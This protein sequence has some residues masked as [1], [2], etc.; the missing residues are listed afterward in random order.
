MFLAYRDLRVFKGKY[1]IIVV[2]IALIALMSTLLSGLSSG[3]V[4]DGI[5]GLRDLPMTHIAFQEGAK[6]SFSR[7]SLN[8][9]NYKIY[10][11]FAQ[12]KDVKI[13]RLGV[14]FFNAK[15]NDG[16]TVDVALFGVPSNSFLAV[17]KRAQDALAADIPGIVLSEKSKKTNSNVKVGDTIQIVG[18]DVDLKVLG[19]T[20][21]GSYGHVPIAITSLEKW[22]EL[23]Y[24]TSAKGRFSAI[25][26]QAES[27]TDFTQ[28]DKAAGTETVT[29][30]KS[31]AGSP[32]YNAETTTMTLIRTFLLLISALIV[33]AFFTVWTIQRIRQIGLLK[34]LGASNWY[35][36]KDSLGQLFVV[37]V[38]GTLSGMSVGI[39]LGS[40]VSSNAPFSIVLSNVIVANLLLVLLGLIG[41]VVAFRR[42]FRVDPIV[43]MG[44]DS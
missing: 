30:A 4:D 10:E 19:Y 38:V 9:R 40:F 7:S 42:I 36:L 15:T 35:V 26:I 39:I 44:T 28:I 37:L 3:L 33:G 1:I 17:D 24:S 16:S 8:D 12:K 23:L 34:A 25:A 43:A 27:N 31:Y 6:E 29:K 18:P 14:A 22:Q 2:L 20:Y 11:S 21:T 5:S 41:S 13:S 32:G